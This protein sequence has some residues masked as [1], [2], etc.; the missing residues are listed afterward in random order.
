MTRIKTSN[1]ISYIGLGIHL[2][3]FIAFT[4][5]ENFKCNYRFFAICKIDVFTLI[6]IV[7]IIIP[8]VLCACSI[9]SVRIKKEVLSKI[10]HISC[11]VILYIW[12][13]VTAIFTGFF[14]GGIS[15]YTDKIDNYG[16]Y[17]EYVSNSLKSYEIED[18]LPDSSIITSDCKYS[19]NYNYGPFSENYRIE[20]EVAF[21]S[22]ETFQ[23]EL[24]RL[25]NDDMIPRD[26]DRFYKVS[27][28]EELYMVIIKNETNKTIKYYIT[29]GL[30]DTILDVE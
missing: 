11:I 16:L 12:V 27:F 25:L 5:I 7:S 20:T 30:G 29:Y 21:K 24:E 19:Y 4:F 9:L 10:I 14:R 17:D 18:F 3:L 23:K 8:L 15:S 2:V 6:L 1:L 28:D 22:E 26:K 13:V